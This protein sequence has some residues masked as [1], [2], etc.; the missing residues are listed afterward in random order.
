MTKAVYGVDI[1]KSLWRENLFQILLADSV[2]AVPGELFSP[3]IDK[4][5]FFILRA[6]GVPV[7]SDIKLKQLTGLCFKL[8]EPESIS[9]SQNSQ[10]FLSG[11]K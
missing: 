10:C 11:S 2:N 4:Q 6:W 7:L 9:F 1:L 5:S 3:L 8:Y